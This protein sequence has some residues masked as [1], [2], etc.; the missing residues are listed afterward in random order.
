MCCGW[1]LEK[2]LPCGDKEDLSS[3]GGR[4]KEE[5]DGVIE[6]V[7][8]RA[9]RKAEPRLFA[10]GLV[11]W[12]KD[13]SWGDGVHT[14]GGLKAPCTGGCEGPLGVNLLRIEIAL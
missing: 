13:G 1:C 2:V 9:W 8:G 4:G 3:D 5:G 6:V 7:K 10:M 11:R 12:R 14:T